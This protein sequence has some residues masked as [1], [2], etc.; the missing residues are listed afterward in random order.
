M[1]VG[2]VVVA[3]GSG[4][5]F[6]A[7]AAPKQFQPILGLPLVVHSVRAVLASR[8]GSRGWW[9]SCP[10]GDSNPWQADLG[11]HLGPEGEPGF[12]L[13]RRGYPARNRLRADWRRSTRAFEEAEGAVADLVA[14]HD[15]ARPAPPLSLVEE[16]IEAGPPPR[17]GDPRV[18][19]RRTLSGG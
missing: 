5:R 9:W 15:G 1:R 11:P 7:G 16:V 4:I 3:A 10:R 6:G 14:V 17:C 13:S 8:N 18:P 19:A 12:L 2:A